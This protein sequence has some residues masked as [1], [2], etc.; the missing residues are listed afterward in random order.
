MRFD[1]RSLR[2]T[3][4]QGGK[5]MKL[6]TWL[7]NTVLAG[8]NQF[9]IAHRKVQVG[10]GIKMYG[11]CGFGGQKGAIRIGDGTTLRSGYAG[12]NMVGEGKLRL[13]AFQG[14][15]ISIGKNCGIS[16][17]LIVSKAGVA[18][19]D[20]VLIGG[21]CRLYDSD[22]HSLSYEARMGGEDTGYVSLPIRIQRGAFIGAHT[23]ILKGVTVGEKSV[24]GAG[25]VVAKS[26]P[27]GE[28][29]AGNPARKIRDLK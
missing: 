19:E 16:N 12:G 4:P 11:L 24:I 22:F 26:V 15:G 14:E 29:W 23:I 21:G 17:S 7:R 1:L 5:E 8:I 6:Y 13:T 27:A 28:C 18:I 20:D 3:H 9:S 2:L 10:S 25:S